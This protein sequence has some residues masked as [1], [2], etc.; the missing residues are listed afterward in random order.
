MRKFFIIG[1]ILMSLCLLS[2]AEGGVKNLLVDPGFEGGCEHGWASYGDA[3]YDTQTYRSGGQSGKAWVWDYGDGLF[4]QYVNVVPGQKYQASVY[5]YSADSDPIQ[6][7]SAAWIQVEWCTADD[8]IISDVIKS[9]ILT[10][11]NDDWQR[12]ST[13]KIVAPA[14]AA[15]AKVK[16]IHLA[17][18]EQ[19]AGACYFDDAEFGVVN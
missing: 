14:A 5:I 15:K 11:A 19:T 7:G 16:V 6:D 3:T 13:P 8:V 18:G 9:N 4:E 17:P 12:F 1:C 2:S 10:E